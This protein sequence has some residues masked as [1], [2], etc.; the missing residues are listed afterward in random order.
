V[1]ADRNIKLIATDLDG[2]LLDSDMGLSPE[3]REAL[4]RCGAAGICVVIATGRSKTSVPECVLD[5]ACIDYLVCANGAKIYDAHTGKQI[6]AKCLTREAVEN[7]R[8]IIENPEVM[9]EVFWDGS[10]YI[11]E[12]CYGDLTRYGIPGWVVEYV[13]ESRIPVP[14]IAAFARAHIDEIEN[15]NFVYGN[16]DLRDW[17]YRRLHGNTLY[18]LTTSM[19]YNLEIGGIGVSKASALEFLCDALDIDARE[20]LC[21][22]DNDNDARMLQF[23]GIGVATDNAS[24]AAKV[25]ADVV[26]LS[27]NEA[28][29]AFALEMFCNKK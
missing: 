23:A 14:D 18:T 24:A 11:S 27:N 19:R 13:R 7:V 6:Y 8:E 5:L 10:P 3:N 29:V 28:G 21:I 2:T 25:A 4:E 26:T 17:I 20:T 1:N 12:T 22:G 9:C 16:E 15:I